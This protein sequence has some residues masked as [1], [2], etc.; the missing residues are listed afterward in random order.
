HAYENERKAIVYLDNDI[1]ESVFR[2]LRSVCSE[3]YRDEFDKSR[4]RLRFFCEKH[5]IEAYTT[6]NLGSLISDI[7]NGTNKSEINVSTKPK[8]IIRELNSFSKIIT[9]VKLLGI[10]SMFI[11]EDNELN[12]WSSNPGDYFKEN[13]RLMK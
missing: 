5:L 1:R 13:I 9:D 8:E 12:K 2:V 7:V 3:R 11:V 6:F 10:E 4:D